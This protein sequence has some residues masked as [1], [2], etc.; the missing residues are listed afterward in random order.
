MI[1]V[2]ADK[3]MPALEALLGH[4]ARVIRVN[5][6]CLT[7]DYL[8]DAEVLLV[9]SVTPVDATLLSG[10]SVR[11]V[12]TATSGT[13]HIDLPW[14]RQQGI[15]FCRAPGA[16][17]NSV[18]EYVLSALV[19]SGEWLETLL[20][21]GRLGVVGYGFVGRAV[22]ARFR[23]LR[24]ECLVYDPWLSLGTGDGAAPLDEVLA[25]EV[26]S[27]HCELT[28]RQPWPSYHLL[29]GD[30][31]EALHSGQLLINSSRGAV[32]D[33]GALNAR[34]S[35][36]DAPTVVLDVWE[37]EPELDLELLGRVQFGT[38]HI[39]GYSMDGKIRATR[40]LCEAVADEFGLPLPGDV[41]GGTCAGEL[42][43]PGHVAGRA[44]I[45]K[46]LI[47]QRYDIRQDDKLLRAAC[48]S[49]DRPVPDAFD[50]LRKHYI[51]RRELAGSVVRVI[52]PG[53][54]YCDVISALGCRVAP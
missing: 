38:A 20:D 9:R 45:V 41:P 6:R 3:N 39:A 22:A 13:D 8:S 10:S 33:N 44:A 34:L 46:Q 49:V 51:E 4:V 7:A 23:A 21:G 19:H 53:D 27:L 29:S 2:V 18:V 16:N 47:Q 25:C 24:V 28:R 32:I 40:M 5:G 43:L 31:L 36:P 52:E 14:L 26:I 12:G 35:R 30:E 15:G 42:S 48:S 17:A 37:G 1:R 54:E 11:F 50:H